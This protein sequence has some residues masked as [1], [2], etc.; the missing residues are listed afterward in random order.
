M[1]SLLNSALLIQFTISIGILGRENSYA[2]NDSNGSSRFCL[3]RA[4]SNCSGDLRR[5]PCG[6]E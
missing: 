6:R 4:L 2:A 3:G 1:H 5:C